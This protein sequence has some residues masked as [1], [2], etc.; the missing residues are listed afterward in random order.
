MRDKV[1]NMGMVI[2]SEMK[3]IIYDALIFS[4]RM[5]L[6][7]RH[8]SLFRLLNRPDYAVAYA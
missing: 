5:F 1:N 7:H 3:I 6:Q 4:H 2:L 8:R